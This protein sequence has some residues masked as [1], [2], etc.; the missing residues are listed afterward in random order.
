MGFEPGWVPLNIGHLTQLASALAL[1]LAACSS[2]PA[3]SIPPQAISEIERAQSL[4]RAVFEHDIAAARATD[5]LAPSGVFQ[6]DQRIRGWITE[7]DDGGWLVR[8]VGE[9]GPA[10]V[11]LYDVRL[12]EPQR[13]IVTV[14]S[15]PDP[16]TIREGA[17][18]RAR[19]A[20]LATPF[21]RCSHAFNTVV[22]PDPD[23][24]TGGWLVYVLA[25]TTTQGE[26]VAG[27]HQR[28]RLSPDGVQVIEHEPLS[29]SCFR[30][31]PAPPEPGSDTVAA[32]VTHLV[33]PT[34]I[35]THVW[36]SLQAGLPIYVGTSLGAWRV[37]GDQIHFVGPFQ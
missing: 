11:A 1:G 19:E 15:P 4:G 8:F 2:R 34:P 21:M 14:M 10:Y 5:A 25:A 22:L 26:I 9:D 28:F 17:M 12:H 16:L 18:Y 24:Q 6:S 31:N 29:E 7:R 27:G 32:V 20:A 33:S 37:D 36:M 13:P 3:P 35:E 30:L 23:S